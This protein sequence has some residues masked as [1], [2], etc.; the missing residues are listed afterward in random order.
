MSELLRG[1]SRQ[2]NGARIMKSALATTRFV[3]YGHCE[4]RVADSLRNNTLWKRVT[5]VKPAN[6]QQA[7]W[8]AR[9]IVDWSQIGVMHRERLV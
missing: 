2:E 8:I 4:K 7:F 5:I 9:T 3:E 1:F 6:S